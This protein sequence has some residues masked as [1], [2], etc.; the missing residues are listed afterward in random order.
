MPVAMTSSDT[1]MALAGPAPAQ[2]APRGLRPV[3]IWLG[4]LAIFVALMVIVGGATRLT[5][6]GL[7]ITEWKPVTGAIPPLSAAHWQAEFAKYQQIPEYQQV[8]RGMSLE[9]FKTIYWWEWGHR[10]LGRLVGVAFL[11]PFLVL[12]ATGHI[13]RWMA[14]RLIGLFILGGLQGAIGWWMVTSGLTERTDVSQY[15]LAVHLT[16]ACFIFA[17]L[18]WTM[19]SLSERAEPHAPARIRKTAW[20]VLA[21]V[22]VQIALG[23][24]VAG[25]DAGL[26]YN[27]WPLMDGDFIP[28]GLLMLEPWWLNLTENITAVQF[29]HRMFAY[30]LTI[31]AFV[32]AW[33]LRSAGLGGRAAALAG[34]VL[35]QILIGIATL[36]H[37]VPLS[38][39]ILH[40]AG[41]LLVLAVAVWNLQASRGEARLIGP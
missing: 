18:I 36:I 32:H 38:L 22:F 30:L 11:V 31:V 9:E 23:A 27:T 24:L 5:D 34:A 6:S 2:A 19:L 29:D 35:L 20:L 37:A 33:Q 28:D 14:P 4:V 40:Q 3:R 7:S 10:F 39:G 1:D 16:M 8:N 25:L 41:A 26:T 15:R 17:A 21:L 12:I 13:R